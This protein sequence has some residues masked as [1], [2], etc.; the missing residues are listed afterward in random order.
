MLD[1]G[2]KTR[3]PNNCLV[4]GGRGFVGSAICQAARRAGWDVTAVGRGDYSHMAGR[5]FDIVINANGNARRYLAE[6]DPAADFDA[7]VRSVVRSLADFSCRHYVLVSTVDVYDD[8]ARE[9]A[10]DENAAIDLARLGPYG[11]HKRLAELCVMRQAPSWQ[12]FRLGQ[13]VG[14]HLRKGPVFDLLHGLPL[15][16]AATSEM[17]FLDTRTMARMVCELIVRAPSGQVYNVCGA[18]SVPF[19]QVLE[20]FGAKDVHVDPAAPS[21]VYR[22]RTDKVRA[23][24]EVPASWDEVR[25]FVE[26]ACRG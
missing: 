13:M 19:T 7:S 15:R 11:F 18:G 8:P 22:I 20:M 21:Q 4:I 23:L 6:R 10:T 14:P 3:E 1:L 2:M 16:I 17:P 25:H 26:G 9:D 12:V 5:P 24:T